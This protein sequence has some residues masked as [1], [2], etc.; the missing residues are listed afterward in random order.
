MFEKFKRKIQPLINIYHLLKAVIANIWYGF[1]SKKLKV[2]GVAGTDGKTTTAHL[3]YYILKSAGKKVSLI[4][5]IYARIGQKEFSTGLHVTTPDALL[6]QKLLKQAVINNDEY[7]V[8]ETTSHGLD[9]NRNWGI[10]YEVGVITNITPEH[11]DY[12]KT[13]EKYVGAKAKLLLQSK[14]PVINVDDQSYK[15][16]SVILR[17][18]G[19]KFATYGLKEKANFSFSPKKEIDQS[20]TKYNNYN[21]LAAYSVAELLKIPTTTVKNALKSFKLPMGRLE[22]VY[23]KDFKVIIDFAHTPNAIY[24]L[25][26]GISAQI[27]EQ[28]KLIHVFGSAG[29]RDQKKRPAMGAASGKFADIVVLTEEDYRTEDPERICAEIAVGLKRKGFQET[30]PKFVVPHAKIYAIIINRRKA[31][32][33]ALKIAKKEDVIVLTGKS[34]EQSLCRGR[35]EYP[36]DEKKVVLNIL[37]AK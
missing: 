30:S 20:I 26:E 3:I 27:S 9:Q 37:Y 6:L 14:V 2:I 35:R 28:G 22:T 16:L 11:L 7:F 24:K 25:L 18:K 33:R 19:R 29:L 1:P 12:H 23:D 34:H 4:S 13:Y 10:R 17:R 31:I 5:S 32:E 15:L 8:L 21:Y 36:W